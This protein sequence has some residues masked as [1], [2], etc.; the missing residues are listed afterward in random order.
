MFVAWVTGI[1]LLLGLGA[2]ISILQGRIDALER[3]VMFL[4]DIIT[5]GSR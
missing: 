2:V 4:H 3:D 5:R 1:A